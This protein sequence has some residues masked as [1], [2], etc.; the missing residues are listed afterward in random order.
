[1]AETGRSAR[2]VN[3]EE[4]NEEAPV[5]RE[6]RGG[7]ITAVEPQK[8]HPDRVSLFLDG[9]FACGLSEETASLCGL[10][11]GRDLSPEEMGRILDQEETRR[12]REAAYLLLS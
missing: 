7:R 9:R 5:I 8:R 11:V 1:M 10:A 4:V 3:E 12:A 2:E 6:A